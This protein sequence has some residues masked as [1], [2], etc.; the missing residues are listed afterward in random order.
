[1]LVTPHIIDPLKGGAVP[2]DPKLSIPYLKNEKF[3]NGVPG[4]QGVADSANPGSK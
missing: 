3:D 2:S 4:H 1:M